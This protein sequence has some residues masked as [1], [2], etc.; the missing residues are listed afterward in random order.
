MGEAGVVEGQAARRVLPARVV[1]EPLDRLAVRA[2]LETLEDHHDRDDE[3][4]DRA[5]P[6]VGEQVA[7]QRVG[8]EREAL[9]VE[10]GVD[11]ILGNPRGAE[12]G[13]ASEDVGLAGRGPERH[14]GSSAR[15]GAVPIRSIRSACPENRNCA[16][17]LPSAP[18]N[19]RFT[20]GS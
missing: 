17:A 19:A 20:P 6:D 16:R 1:G 5:P 14:G 7:E 9:P 3:R 15:S 2:A 11:R 12:L 8:E 10:Q 18:Q 13:R 4:R